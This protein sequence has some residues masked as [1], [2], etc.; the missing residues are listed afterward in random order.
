MLLAYLDTNSGIAGDM[1][2]CAL[3]DAGADASYIQSQI[4]SLGLPQVQL[5]FSETEK[6]CFR[7]L[8][9]DV[10]H[11]PEHAHRHLSD[12]ETMIRSSKLLP[13]EQ[14]IALRLFRK[15]GVAEAKVHGTTIEQV[16]F[17]EVGAVDSIVDIVGIAV[18]LSNLNI[19]RIIASPTPTGCG[20]ISIAHG[21]VSVPAPATAELLKGVPVLG[22][23]IEAELTTPT[24]A[25]VLA[26]LADG[27][28]ALP[29]MQIE[30]IGYGAGH[31]DLVEQAN[32]LRVIVGTSLASH[33]DD[34]CVLE[35][36]LDD[37]TGEQIGF[38]IDQLWRAGALDVFTT[39]IQMKKNRPA[40][41][42]SVICRPESRDTVEAA[43]F[44]HSGSLGIRRSHMQRR[45]LHREVIKVATSLGEV[46]VKV[47]W[48]DSADTA[49]PRCSPEYDDCKRLAEE[50]GKT[51]EAIFMLA[52]AAAEK[53]VQSLTPPLS[54]DENS[55]S[56]DW[57]SPVASVD[58]D[59][60]SHSHHHDH[61]HD[62]H[63]HH[64]H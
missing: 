41:L 46:R 10:E 7:A 61:D 22:S 38:T 50:H 4:D 44:E 1:M 26:T 48:A 57:S 17:H 18:A 5:K 12:I 16:H 23:P 8:R 47:A 2:L 3:V 55:K 39:P 19:T 56:L 49:I 33:Q 63:D 24:G 11:P 37:V 45:K 31:R 52:L 43:L 54:M 64:H 59:A 36:N 25:A 14:D 27:F 60:N 53:A 34:V 30:R 40:T 9:L 32:I 13:R 51:L 62:H 6:H 20:K 29:A 58:Q 42:L 21:I 35:T 28:G 15:V